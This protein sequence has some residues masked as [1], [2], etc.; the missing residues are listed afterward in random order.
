MLKIGL[1]NLLIF[2]ESGKQHLTTSG[3][4][5]PA[6]LTSGTSLFRLVSAENETKNKIGAYT[7]ETPDC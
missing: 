4:Q 1:L 7:K 6:N 3:I 2:P 5:N